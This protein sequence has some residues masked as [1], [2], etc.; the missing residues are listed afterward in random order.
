MTDDIKLP[1]IEHQAYLAAI[2]TSSQDAI[3][4]KDLNGNIT[5]WNPAAER[6]FGHTAEEIIGKHITI[7]I[8][9]ERLEE[10][11]YII[12]KVKSGERVEHFHTIRRHKDGRN[13]DISVTV[14]PI[15]SSSGEIIGASKIARDIA[16]L[17]D[18]ERDSAYLSAIIENSED[19]IVSKNLNGIITS[20]NKSAE[21]IF[22]YTATEA[23]GKHISLIIPSDRLSE[24]DK[25]I[26]ALRSK[27]RVDHF[28]TW[29]RHKNGSP[30]S[31]LR[32]YLSYL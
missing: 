12:G 32:Y 1:P 10:E 19:A 26:S 29:R 6:I 4:S 17:K 25:I 30:Y 7:L 28:Q 23:V 2:I 14:S 20:W 13:I 16:S 24:E 3:I 5:S 18:A 9:A 21:R 15:R 31:N 8:P 27:E 22:G 11:K